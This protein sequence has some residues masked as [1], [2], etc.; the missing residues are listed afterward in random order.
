MQGKKREWLH[1]SDF[2]LYPDKEAKEK[3]KVGCCMHCW[4]EFGNERT[5]RYEHK[6]FCTMLNSKDE[7][8]MV[9][10]EISSFTKSKVRNKEDEKSEKLFFSFVKLQRQ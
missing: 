10:T 7:T 6:N 4:K 5:L 8:K 1:G 2:L 3:G 9:Q